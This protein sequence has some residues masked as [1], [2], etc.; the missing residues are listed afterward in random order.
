MMGSTLG[1]LTV[2]LHA[3]LEP[4]L[5]PI[6]ES[7]LRRCIEYVT[8]LEG[9]PSEYEE[10]GREMPIDLSVLHALAATAA[11][12]VLD[13]ERAKAR[14]KLLTTLPCNY[15]FCQ[16]LPKQGNVKGSR[17]KC[18]GCLLAYYCSPSCQKKDWTAGHRKICKMLA[19][20]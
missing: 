16:S 12:A 13:E 17:R 2:K 18:S 15:P 6:D 4:A 14:S 3:T 20:D 10:Y 7:P 8:S 11:G 1:K 19:E 9:D 5:L